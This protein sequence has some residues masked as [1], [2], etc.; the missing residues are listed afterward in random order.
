MS[1]E[2]NCEEKTGNIYTEAPFLIFLSFLISFIVARAYVFFLGDIATGRDVFPFEYYMVH[3]FYYGVILMIIAGW[4]AIIYKDRDIHRIAALL[5]GAGLGIFFD[6][7]GLLLTHFEDYWDPITY[8]AVV[9]IALILLNII[10]FKRFWRSFGTELRN[11]VVDKKLH[12]GPFNLVGVVDVMDETQ[13]KIPKTNRIVNIFMGIVLFA[14]GTLVIIYP[15]LLYYWV[16]A[17]FFLTG[18][19]YL[20]KGAIPN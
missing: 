10:F 9:I 17:A 5:Y 4:I 15:A 2:K 14:A 11:L 8:T 20:I 1:S 7:L 16:A 18:L 13:N 6:E 19:S 12:Y 3:H